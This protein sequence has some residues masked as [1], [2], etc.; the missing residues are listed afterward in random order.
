MDK[1][2]GN[3]SVCAYLI[4]TLFK[5]NVALNRFFESIFAIVLTVSFKDCSNKQ[6]F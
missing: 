3:A 6:N 1:M 5:K 4:G 2:S